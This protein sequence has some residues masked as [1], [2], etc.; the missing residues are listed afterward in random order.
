[1]QAEIQAKEN[2]EKAIIKK[3][4]EMISKL[5]YTNSN[6]VKLE[7]TMKSLSLGDQNILRA[8]WQKLL[9]AKILKSQLNQKK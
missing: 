7:E 3:V 9:K 2:N 6:K 8:R 4:T 1:M 5:P